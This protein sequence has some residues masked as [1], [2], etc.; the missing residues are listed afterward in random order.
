MQ[1]DTNGYTIRWYSSINKGT[2]KVSKV[3]AGTMHLSCT[4]YNSGGW[5]VSE[6]VLSIEQSNNVSPRVSGGAMTGLDGGTLKNG[7]SNRPA[8]GLADRIVLK[9]GATVAASVDTTAQCIF[10]KDVEIEGPAMSRSMV[11]LRR[12]STIRF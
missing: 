5:E 2:G 12:V 6:G 7:S 9:E 8:N 1:I 10:G 4:S 3:G 11:N